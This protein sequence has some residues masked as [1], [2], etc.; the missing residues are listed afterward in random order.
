MRKTV[1]DSKR[2]WDLKLTAALWAYRTTYKVAT[3]ATNFSLV[4]EL[5]AILPIKY[6]VESLWVAIGSRLTESQSLRNRLTDLKELDERR[7]MAVQHIEAIQRRRMITFDKRHNKRA[8]RPG[9]MVMI[10]DARRFEFPGK[11]DAVW[12]GLYLVREAF[13]KSSLQLET[14][15]EE[16]F[17]IRKS[18]SR[19][20]EYRA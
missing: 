17:P 8:L 9:M 2:D 1:L 7:R 13:P 16:S 3:Q 10:Q 15:N 5:D 4:Y 11:F 6:E 19:C 12:L 14:L 18:G 20:K